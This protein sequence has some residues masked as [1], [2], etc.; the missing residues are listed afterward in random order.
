MPQ[1]TKQ[2]FVIRGVC[3]YHITNIDNTEPFKLYAE[4]IISFKFDIN[5]KIIEYTDKEADISF[6]KSA[7]EWVIV[8]DDLPL[9]LSYKTIKLLDIWFDENMIHEKDFKFII[10]SFASTSKTAMLSVDLEEGH[11]DMVVIEGKDAVNDKPMQ[12]I[13]FLY[14]SDYC[15][16]VIE[17]ALNTIHLLDKSTDTKY[18]FNVF[19]TSTTVDDRGIL[20]LDA[21]GVMY[22]LDNAIHVSADYITDDDS[23]FVFTGIELNASFDGEDGGFIDMVECEYNGVRIPWHAA[24]APGFRL[25][26]GDEQHCRLEL[27]YYSTDV[28]AVINNIDWV[29]ISL[30]DNVD[31]RVMIDHTKP[32]TTSP[33]YNYSNT[34]QYYI[35]GVGGSEFYS[36]DDDLTKIDWEG[37][38]ISCIKWHDTRPT[39]LFESAS[40][41][42][43]GK[44]YGIVPLTGV[45]DDITKNEIKRQKMAIQ[46]KN[47]SIPVQDPVFIVS[48]EV[49]SQDL[50]KDLHSLIH[51]FINLDGVH[52]NISKLEVFDIVSSGAA[53][54]PDA[55]MHFVMF[56]IK[57]IE[58]GS[59]GSGIPV[60]TLHFG[61]IVVKDFDFSDDRL[62]GFH[63]ELKEIMF[64]GSTVKIA[65]DHIHNVCVDYVEPK[66]E[67]VKTPKKE[68]T[69]TY[70]YPDISLVLMVHGKNPEEIVNEIAGMDIKIG[71]Y[72]YTPQEFKT[73]THSTYE[74]SPDLYRVMVDFIACRNV[75]ENGNEVSINCI[76]GDNPKLLGMCGFVC[77]K[78]PYRVEVV[79]G[80]I[81]GKELD[82]SEFDP[83]QSVSYQDIKIP[84]TKEKVKISVGVKITEDTKDVNF[85]QVRAISLEE[86][87][88]PGEFKVKN[89]EPKFV[90]H[91][92]SHV[93]IDRSS[94]NVCSELVV[95]NGCHIGTVMV[96][97]GGY[98]T[99]EEGGHIDK[100]YVYAGG[101]A[102]PCEGAIVDHVLELGG[103][104]YGSAAN[105][106]FN[107]V[108]LTDG[109]I[110]EDQYATI[111]EGSMMRS[112]N[113]RG[114]LD[115][116]DNSYTYMCCVY[117]EFDIHGGYHEHVIVEPGGTVFIDGGIVKHLVAAKGSRVVIFKGGSLFDCEF[118][119]TVEYC[120]DDFDLDPNIVNC[121]NDED[122]T[123][124]TLDDKLSINDALDEL[125][126]D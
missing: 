118:H 39:V 113:I 19:K 35:S 15:P 84:N 98:L 86:L 70:R 1:D 88:A 11:C 17:A 101:I 79:R 62:S 20:V 105:I 48:A 16:E 64:N 72:V 100:L 112:C 5:G 96:L 87:K 24:P 44:H 18:D 75:D 89:P 103:A 57:P 31:I 8:L 91:S 95:Q 116:H 124:F 66:I 97:N 47:S 83:I 58:M 82:L 78:E 61:N 26:K 27:I 38:A 30:P 120:G 104:F 60:K 40:M 13:K 81:N 6:D 126:G 12:H 110:A 21:E 119:G 74:E 9:E 67:V 29:D 102:E 117:G 69:K 114:K 52:H 25:I 108:Y 125:K 34:S 109:N 46:L 10:H 33:G 53:G 4:D 14:H 3:H 115:A 76:L 121:N 77:Y 54:L 68:V 111:H 71:D 42:I 73:R 123:Y 94:I 99:I 63:M 41:V 22:D 37:A 43:S 23:D 28:N 85:Y 50:G 65:L 51:M 122:I 93:S 7:G 56:K 106:H 45:S 80:D 49:R 90:T 55:Q 92:N 32:V 2:A 59:Y 107:A 36:G